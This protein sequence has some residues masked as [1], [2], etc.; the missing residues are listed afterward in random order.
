[1][2]TK[3]AIIKSTSLSIEDH[4]VLSAWLHLDYGGSGQGFG[5]YMLAPLELKRAEATLNF[6]GIFIARTLQIVGVGKWENLAGKTIRVR[7]EGGL[8]REIGHFINDEWF[9]PREVFER[10]EATGA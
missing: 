4:G 8:A 9:N 7:I 3:N 5:G 1:M 10:M 2:E 6:A